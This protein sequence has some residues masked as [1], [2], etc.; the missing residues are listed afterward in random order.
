MAI[1]LVQVSVKSVQPFSRYEHFD[2]DH[3]N[4]PQMYTYHFFYLKESE[5]FSCVT[6]L[7]S[8]VSGL[9][10]NRFAPDKSQST[11]NSVQNFIINISKRSHQFEKSVRNRYY[12]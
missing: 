5:I 6:F 4:I 12:S 10:R 3:V 7:L 1:N 11:R 2:G 8:Y 9:I